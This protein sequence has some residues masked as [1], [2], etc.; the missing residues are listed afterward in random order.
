MRLSPSTVLFCGGRTTGCSCRRRH[1]R[2]VKKKN[3]DEIM[4]AGSS[5]GVIM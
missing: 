3:Y 2:L 1:H 4:I 5:T